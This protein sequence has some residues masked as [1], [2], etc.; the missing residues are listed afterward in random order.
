MALSG[1]ECKKGVSLKVI[2]VLRGT[3]AV[4]KWNEE[5]GW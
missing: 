5:E 3:G 4:G 2:S 1:R